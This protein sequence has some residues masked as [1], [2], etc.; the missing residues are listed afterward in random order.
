MG[1][2]VGVVPA[3]PDLASL[4]QPLVARPRVD[5]GPRLG[6]ST[7]TAALDCLLRRGFLRV[8]KSTAAAAAAL[9]GPHLSGFASTGGCAE[10]RFHPPWRTGSA[11][12]TRASSVSRRTGFGRG[13]YGVTAAEWIGLRQTDRR[14]PAEGT[15]E[16]GPP[17]A[18]RRVGRSG[19]RSSAAA[20]RAD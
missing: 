8:G 14:T 2:S 10:S 3:I 18:L 9:D 12:G 4:L 19:T 13:S 20:R 15:G 7:A 5:D 16:A 17:R 6:E 1:E 11:R